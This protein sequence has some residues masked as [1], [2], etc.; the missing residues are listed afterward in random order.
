M[1]RDKT[2]VTGRSVRRT[3]HSDESSRRMRAYWPDPER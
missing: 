1:N 2:V 3:A